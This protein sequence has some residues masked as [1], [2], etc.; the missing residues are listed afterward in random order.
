MKFFVG[1]GGYRLD[2]AHCRS[3]KDKRQVLK[4]ILDRLGNRRWVGASEVGQND[5]WKSGAIAVVCVSQTYGAAEES[6]SSARRM[7]ESSGVDVLE[8]QIKVFNPEDLA[9]G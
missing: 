4:S 5:V 1:I 2:L 6:L 3:L 8:Q 9:G 7:I